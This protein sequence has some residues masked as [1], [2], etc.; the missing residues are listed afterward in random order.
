MA[1][2]TLSFTG[3]FKSIKISLESKPV[4]YPPTRR[5]ELGAPKILFTLTF[6]NIQLWRHIT[7]KNPNN[8]IQKVNSFSVHISI[9]NTFSGEIWHDL[10]KKRLFPLGWCQLNKYSLEPP[11]LIRLVCLNGQFYEHICVKIVVTNWNR[12]NSG[13]WIMSI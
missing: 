10:S 8:M 1:T 3:N 13:I 12:M 6:H 7:W 5:V 4:P 11:D 9:F 2:F